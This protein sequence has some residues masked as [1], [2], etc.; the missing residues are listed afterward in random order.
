MTKE[1]VNRL[2]SAETKAAATALTGKGTLV[3]KGV[4]ESATGRRRRIC[5]AIAAKN[6][7]ING[8]SQPTVPII[9][10]RF[11]DPTI[12]LVENQRASKLRTLE[13]QAT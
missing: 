6:N 2:S 3:L 11:A 4:H 10:D 8:I 9:P 1:Q 7:F 5:A 13:K 12:K